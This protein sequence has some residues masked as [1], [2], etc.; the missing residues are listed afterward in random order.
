MAT[1][2]D[3][4]FQQFLTDVPGAAFQSALPSELKGKRRRFAQSQFQNLMDQFLGEQGAMVRGG[5]MPQL[6]AGDWFTPERIRRELFSFS[7][8][9][10][11]F[12]TARF[13]P[14]VEFQF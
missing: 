8:S 5:M 9:E 11:G 13:A 3:F 1:A 10:R 2:S 6:P 7:P 12:G 4:P 14:P